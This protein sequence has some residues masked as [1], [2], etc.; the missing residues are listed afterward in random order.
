M[1]NPP[2]YQAFQAKGALSIDEY[3]RLAMYHPEHGYYAQHIPIGQDADYVTS[4]EI[5]QVFGEL[6]GLW[7][8]DTWQKLG[9]PSKIALV[10]LGPG[11]GT[12]MRD[13][14]RVSNLVP[15]FAK[16]LS[17][18]LIEASALLKQ[19]QSKKI[20]PI[21]PTWHY[22]LTSLP[23]LPCLIIANEFF[24]A[25]PHKQY[26]TY[27]G[28]WFERMVTLNDHELIWTL[29]PDPTDLDIPVKEGSFTEVPQEG[30]QILHQLSTHL[31]RNTGA[32]LI[33]DYGTS[34]HPWYGD[35]FQALHHH[36][37][38][39]PLASP[40]TCD[41]TFHVNF[42]HLEQQ[43]HQKKIHVEPVVSQAH[44]LK[45]LG[46]E[47]RTAQLQHMPQAALAS[48]RLIS[49]QHMGQ[50]FKVLGASSPHISLLG[51]A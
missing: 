41:L 32:C 29:A 43:F 30:S 39:S 15:A 26:Q 18:H 1:F 37:K 51:F 16:A 50:L 22:D 38:C 17:I 20:Y 14:L 12:L 13:L 25:L 24:D 6:I 4:P 34:A 27:Q 45:S 7:C 47:H 42:H 35:T 36:K 21:T 5:S 44:F 33:I 46:I 49:A 28:Q 8:I 9:S 10:E 19:I 3:F 31:S 11:R 2:L 48:Y 23:D 40:G